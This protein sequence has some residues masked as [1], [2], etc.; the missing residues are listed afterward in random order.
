MIM[1][2][3]IEEVAKVS[4]IYNTHEEEHC[5]FVPTVKMYVIICL[6]TFFISNFYSKYYQ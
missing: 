3:T 4:H 6:V 5:V 2:G 1:P